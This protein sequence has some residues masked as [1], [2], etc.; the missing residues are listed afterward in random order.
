M[1]RKKIIKF[2][3]FVLFLLLFTSLNSKSS[4]L[5][6]NLKK[7]DNKKYISFNDVVSVFKF[8][9]TFDVILQRGKFFYKNHYAVMNVGMSVVLV[10]GKLYKSFD[11]VKRYKGEVLIPLGLFKDII[12]HLMPKSKINIVKSNKLVIAFPLNKK[13]NIIHKPKESYRVMKRSGD[14]IKFI[15]IDAG[16]GGK[17]P[18]AVGKGKVTEKGITLKVART[19]GFILKRKL[20]GVQIRY[21]RYNDKFI[22]LQRR[23]EIANRLLKKNQNGLFLSIH[24]NASIS[25]RISG[26]E[27]Y[28]LSQ[29]AS[30]E[31]ARN[32]A[33]LENDV[34]VLEENKK[35]K[36]YGDI[37]YME[38]MMLTS[39]IQ[40]ESSIL[41]DSIQSGMVKKNRLFKSRGVRKADFF[42]L[43]GSLMPAALVEIGFITNKKELKYLKKQKHRKKIAEGIA[44]GVYLFIKKYNKMLKTDKNMR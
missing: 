10:D 23:T 31:D 3:F 17:D 9:Y 41:A 18:G 2:F 20:K 6:I 34:V 7:I 19:L 22:S 42:V 28:F 5:S 44:Q 21:T 8:N 24:V 4:K 29:N 27:T 39:Q 32:T 33:A 11:K 35:H 36:S 30:N 12:V 38:A 43:R 13:K 40:K 16:H 14:K 37:D 26:Y 15:V 25:P 1:P